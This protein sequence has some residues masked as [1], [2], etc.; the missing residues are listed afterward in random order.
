MKIEKQVIHRAIITVQQGKL[1]GEEQATIAVN[2]QRGHL[3]KSI[4][5]DDGEI[6]IVMEMEGELEEVLKT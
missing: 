3:I 4:S 5:Q 1:T 6:I 2:I